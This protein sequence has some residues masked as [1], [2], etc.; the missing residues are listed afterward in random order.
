MRRHNHDGVD[1][2]RFGCGFEIRFRTRVKAKGPA[3][4]DSAV[5]FMIDRKNH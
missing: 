1:V 4:F 5:P 2:G 3:D